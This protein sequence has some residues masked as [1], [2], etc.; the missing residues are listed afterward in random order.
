MML[1]FPAGAVLLMI[2]F[3]ACS[4]APTRPTEVR[5]LRNSAAAQLELLNREADRGNYEGALEI[6][7]QTRP[8]ALAADDPELLV[9]TGLSLGNILFF[10]GRVEESDRALAEAR[11]L[12]AESG[13]GELA[14]IAAVYL[15]RQ[16][17]LKVLGRD[18]GGTAAEVRDRVRRE[19]AAIKDDDL[20]AAL[21]WTVA[22]LAEKEL[23]RYAE[24]EA[25]FME[26]L[27]IHEKGPYLEQA[28]Y[29]WYLIASA[30]SVGGR[31]REALAALDQALSFDRRAENSRGLGS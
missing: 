20:A 5:A 29:D 21:A 4:T 15:E 9:R 14:A 13:D 19:A 30:R 1:R 26:A 17:L 18:G 11:T 6:M 12:A 24:A 10:L 23:R 28:A 31:Y 25:A 7:N 3:A 8:L 2:L 16:R 22:G 27:K